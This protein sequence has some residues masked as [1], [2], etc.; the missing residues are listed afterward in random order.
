MDYALVT[1]Y[2]SFDAVRTS[3]RWMPRV[4]HQYIMGIMPPRTIPVPG[5]FVSGAKEGAIIIAPVTAEMMAR[6]RLA[7]AGARGA[8]ALSWALSRA[9]EEARVKGARQVAADPALSD[10]QEASSWLKG[11]TVAAAGVLSALEQSMSSGK[12]VPA[13]ELAIVG[14]GFHEV[15]ALGYALAPLVRGVNITGAR[16]DALER[17]ANCFWRETGVSPRIHK[18]VSRSL[19]R[20][21]LLLIAGPVTAGEVR[22]PSGAVVVE[23]RPPWQ[24]TGSSNPPGDAVFIQAPVFELPV[25]LP[26]LPGLDP[27][28]MS[29]LIEAAMASSGTGEHVAALRPSLKD[30]RKL[31][32]ALS[33]Q[34]AKTTGV[35]HK[36][37]IMPVSALTLLLAS[38]I[39]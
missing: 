19:A 24:V 26:A 16:P 21:R 17:L 20:S 29:P 11:R 15:M 8:R 9:A 23:T 13:C 31:Q 2:K 12:R 22:V 14:T 34:G 39:M 5:G 36:S 37:V 38:P 30:L 35:W 7:S 25:P 1:L 10:V 4:F 33:R 28:V 3:W 32:A 18:D 6:A 27:P